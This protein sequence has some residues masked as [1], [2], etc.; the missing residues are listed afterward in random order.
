MRV[1]HFVHWG[2]LATVLVVASACDEKCTEGI[3]LRI[4]NG[5]VYDPETKAGSI[6]RIGVSGSEAFA[7]WIPLKHFHSGDPERGLYRSNLKGGE[8]LTF[9]AMLYDANL[10]LRALGRADATATEGQFVDIEVQSYA[11]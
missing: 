1:R 2:L 9:T 7:V 5:N 10:R 8:P 4:R 6:L 11:P 3:C